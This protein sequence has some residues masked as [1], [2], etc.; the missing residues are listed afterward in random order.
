VS[1][2]FYSYVVKDAE[3]GDVSLGHGSVE[4][5][6]QYAEG[7]NMRIADN[8]MEQIVLKV[9]NSTTKW[10][11]SYGVVITALNKI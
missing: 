2:Y 1:I 3:L 10:H 5:V 11:E 7:M 9:K 4:V 6:T 8:L